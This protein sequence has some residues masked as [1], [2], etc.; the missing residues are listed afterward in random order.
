MDDT[1]FVAE[2]YSN[3]LVAGEMKQKLG[4]QSIS[5][6]NATTF[7]DNVIMPTIEV[8][9]TTRF[10]TLLTVMKDSSSDL[11][12][13]LAGEI[14][15]MIHQKSL[16]NQTGICIYNHTNYIRKNLDYINSNNYYLCF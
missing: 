15:S 2:L 3:G 11:M 5:S 14:L 12:K 1:M 10:H 9:D 13:D 4:L 6:K 7:L 16:N 8:G